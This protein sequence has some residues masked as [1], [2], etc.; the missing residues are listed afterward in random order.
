[1][2]LPA[3]FRMNTFLPPALYTAAD[4]QLYAVPGWF[5]LP[6]GTTLAEVNERWVRDV[7]TAPREAKPDHLISER[8]LSSKG[9][10]EYEVT[11]DG[12][13]WNCSCIGFQCRKRCRHVD[14][15]KKR[16]THTQTA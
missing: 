14:E 10:S 11:F 5:K 16:H 8:V 9:D 1:M 15:V 12:T 3:N 7:S 4:G 2:S 13:W 6:T